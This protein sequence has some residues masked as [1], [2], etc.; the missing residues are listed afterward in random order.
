MFARVYHRLPPGQVAWPSYQYRIPGSYSKYCLS[1]GDPQVKYHRIVTGQLVHLARM[2]G[3]D[4]F[5]SM[6][7]LFAEDYR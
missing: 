7:K 1:H 3:D 5:L 6:S 4:Y 2:S